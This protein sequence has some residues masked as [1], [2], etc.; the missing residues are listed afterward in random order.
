MAFVRVVGLAGPRMRPVMRLRL[1]IHLRRRGVGDTVCPE[2]E[3]LDTRTDPPHC[4]LNRFAAQITPVARDYPQ[5]PGCHV[6]DLS[7][8]WCLYA[9]GTDGGC[10]S[11][12]ECDPLDMALHYQLGLPGGPTNTAIT[13]LK[14]GVYT[15]S[16]Y[17][18]APNRNLV[19]PTGG[20]V[21]VPATESA[22]QAA[23]MA[24]LGKDQLKAYQAAVTPGPTKTTAPGNAP[25]GSPGGSSG[26]SS[27]G[28]S[29]AATDTS[30]PFSFLTNPISLFG[31][32]I[33]TWGIF[34]G[35]GVGAFAF[36]GK[37]R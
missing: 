26:G 11:M 19:N 27:N 29:G 25:A 32:S 15:P 7:K 9:D 4:I 2:G 20:T 33:P 35:L 14:T 22:V 16:P 8:N 24:A 37:H 31:F 18:S 21:F 30:S 13:A 34:L 6:V 12:P 10:N 28:G 1:P 36:A 3:T 23:M 17:T 5:A